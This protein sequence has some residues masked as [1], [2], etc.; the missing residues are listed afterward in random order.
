MTR[1]TFRVLDF[2]AANPR[3]DL[4]LAVNSNLGRRLH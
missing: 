1:N 2:I 3:A 4:D